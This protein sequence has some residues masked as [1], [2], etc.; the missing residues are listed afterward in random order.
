MSALHPLHSVHQ[1]S[2]ADARALAFIEQR[3]EE[4]LALAIDLI[5]APTQN[6]PGNEIAA[7]QIAH[8]ALLALGFTDLQVVEPEPGRGNLLCTWRT[9]RPGKRLLLNGHL[10]TK[11]AGDLGLWQTDPWRGT[12]VDGR[13]HGLGS[14]DMKGPDAAL[15]FALAA[16]AHAASEAHVAGEVVLALTADEEGDARHGAR[17]L[18]QEI[19][20]L[21]DEALIAEPSGILAPWDTLPL[22]SRGFCGLRFTVTGTQT[23]SSIG[24][25]LP[26]TNATLAAARLLLHLHE[27]LHLRHPATPFCPTGPTVNLG[28]T[29][30]GGTALA[31]QS[32]R[33]DFSVDI[34]TLPGMTQAELA[35]DID[36]AIAAFHALHGTADLALTWR[37][38]DGTLAWTPPTEVARDLPLVH[39]LQDAT[40]IVLGRVPPLGYFPG[41]T[42]AIWWQA[43]GGIPTVPGYGPGLLSSAHRPNESVG[44]EELVDAAGIYA[45]TILH[46]L[47]APPEEVR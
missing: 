27:T 38:V 45:L 15:T 34:R 35:E 29:I 10:D 40:R 43:E 42:D 47:A 21:A 32:G 16:A 28:A 37:F 9:G 36:A 39:A 31:I 41:G 5:A 13:L 1:R 4:L 24:D 25:R 3:R 8:Q 22:I 23:H 18:V 20:L 2:G 46:T 33:V 12:V 17:Y 7:V 44:I 11:P 26:V 30:Q 19:G 6:P 14:V